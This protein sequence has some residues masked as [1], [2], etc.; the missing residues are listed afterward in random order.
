MPRGINVQLWDS[1]I[2]VQA[3]PGDTAAKVAAR[4]GVPA[5]AVAQIN[6]VDEGSTLA[7]GR[8]IIIPRDLDAPPPPAVGGPLTSY[9]APAR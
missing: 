7:T 9:L 4:F 2:P 6:D 3:E 8:R 5:W 1:G